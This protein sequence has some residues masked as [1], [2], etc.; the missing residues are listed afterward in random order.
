MQLKIEPINR[1]N[2]FYGNFFDPVCR[3]FR[4]ESSEI[5]L[6]VPHS[7]GIVPYRTFEKKRKSD[8]IMGNYHTDTSTVP[9]PYW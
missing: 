5:F 9:I 4:K 1:R 6:P 8:A 7:T 3:F 2:F